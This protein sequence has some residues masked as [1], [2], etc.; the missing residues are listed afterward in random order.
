MWVKDVGGMSAHCFTGPH[1]RMKG[2]GTPRLHL[3]FS[4]KSQGHSYIHYLKAVD[5]RRVTTGALTQALPVFVSR[6][7]DRT[8]VHVS[9]ERVGLSE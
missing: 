7:L 8:A 3:T 9:V 5:S 1:P 2:S 6:F 4:L